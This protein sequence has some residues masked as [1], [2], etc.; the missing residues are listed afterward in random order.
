MDKNVLLPYIALALVER[1]RRAEASAKADAG[2]LLA[3]LDAVL[4]ARPS[5][6]EGAAPD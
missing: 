1:L 5:V 2:Q 3:A 6:P 4:T